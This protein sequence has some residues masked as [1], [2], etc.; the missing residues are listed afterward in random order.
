MVG[1]LLVVT[2]FVWAKLNTEVCLF[3]FL[4]CLVAQ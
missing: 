4:E 3:V 2:V 1:S